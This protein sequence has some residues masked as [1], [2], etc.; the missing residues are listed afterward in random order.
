MDLRPL[1]LLPGMVDLHVH[2][3]QVPSA[4]LGAGLD[5]LTWLERHIFPLER[6]YDVPTAER[7]A[8]QVFRAMAAA[9]TTTVVGYGAIWQDSL[10]ATFRAAETH[11]I[12]AVIGKVMMDRITYNQAIAPTRS[13]SAACA[14]PRSCARPGTA[15]TPAASSTRSRP[16]SRSAA[17]RRCCRDAQ[18][19]ARHGAYWQTH[20]SED[21]GE[22]ACVRELFP[23]A[24]DYLDV[25]DRAGGVAPQGDPGPR[26]PPVGARDRPAG[27][28]GRG[29]RP[30]PGEQPVPRAG[31]M[32]LAKY[33]AAGLHVG[34]GSDVAAA[35]EL[36]IVTQMR[37][38][39]YA[40][41]AL[42]IAGR[43]GRRTAAGTARLA[44]AW[45]RWAG[46]GR[47]AWTTAS[48]RWRP[49]RRPT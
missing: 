28:D 45:A 5:L 41:H 47:W 31:V 44:A 16:G 10:D 18:A 46:R 34:L 33:R 2:L 48:A 6:G 25:Y 37:T 32:P 26:D 38:G 27:G 29:D 23:D 15:A 20:L 22:I 14:S 8:P 4:G 19:A 42:S 36:S 9:G 43:G 7:L 40:A 11:G 30:L 35:P 49:A 12:R 21:A 39:F 3:P 24:A 13:W 1:V 17:P